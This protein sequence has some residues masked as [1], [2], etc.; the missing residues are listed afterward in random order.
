M[1]RSRVTDWSTRWRPFRRPSLR[2]RI[3][4]G[5]AL[6]AFSLSVLLAVLVWVFVSNYLLGQRE[7]TALRQTQINISVLQN[8]LNAGAPDIPELL[9]TLPEAPE[10]I[11]LLYR[12]GQWYSRTLDV[13]PEQLP[14]GLRDLVLNGTPAKQRVM[15]NDLPYLT[16]GVPLEPGAYFELFPLTELDETLRTMSLVLPAA[17]ALTAIVGA[18]IG[19]SASRRALAPLGPVAAAAG[20][21]AR[22]DRSARLDA[23]GDPDLAELADS[24][25]TTA[26]DLQRRVEADARF[27]ADVSHELRTPLTTM[28][29]SMEL[30]RRRRDRLPD[31]VQ[32]PLD[33]LADDLHRFHRMVGDLLEISRVEEGVAALDREPVLLGELVTRAADRAAGRPVTQVSPGA[34]RLRFQVDKRRLEQ[35]VTNLVV[36]A[37][38][39]GRGLLRVAVERCPGGARIFV[40][41]SGPGVPA[42]LRDRVF[43][44]FARNSGTETR[45]AGLGLAIVV[46]HVRL[47][48]GDV[49][50]SDRPGGGARFVVELPDEAP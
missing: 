23:G 27:A 32:E 3:T 47:H 31:D 43:E 24:F 6:L 46:R 10:S 25:N 11:V 17:A 29:N 13:A 44:R 14:A 26:D 28:L 5:F 19:R 9:A 45:G 48:G 4:V 7:S 22:G 21:I 34:E 8:S 49:W 20:A 42:D 18:A 39:H 33:L 41:D 1:S 37:E 2:E 40:D 38:T 16:V 30:L 35:V 15:V 50:A 36:N 12:S